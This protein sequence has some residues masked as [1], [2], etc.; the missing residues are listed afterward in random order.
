MKKYIPIKMIR[1]GRYKVCFDG[2][3]PEVQAVFIRTQTLCQGG[4][5]CDFCF[6]RHRKGEVW[7][8]TK[9]I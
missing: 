3:E 5:K 8:R 6:V 2:L 9:S 4:D 1:A 7:E